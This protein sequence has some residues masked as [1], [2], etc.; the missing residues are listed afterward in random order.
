MSVGDR[1]TI[2]SHRT[3]EEECRKIKVNREKNKEMKHVYN[4][5][6]TSYTQTVV[7]LVPSQDRHV[8][9]RETRTHSPNLKS[10]VCR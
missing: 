5:S 7:Y 4:R 2:E 8:N 6:V 10:R 1:C 9:E 3:Q